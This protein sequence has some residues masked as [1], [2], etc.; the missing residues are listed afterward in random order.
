VLVSVAHAT[1]SDLGR[2]PGARKYAWLTYSVPKNSNAT[3]T[4]REQKSQPIGFSDRRD[5]T[6][7]PAVA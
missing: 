3:T 2:E 6:I 7:A 5:A 1:Q 4:P